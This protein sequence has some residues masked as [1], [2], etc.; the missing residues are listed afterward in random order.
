MSE[1]RTTT[2]VVE[3]A[4]LQSFDDFEQIDL[5]LRATSGRTT[6][7]PASLMPK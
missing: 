2:G 5:A 7:W 1:K 6:T 4:R 3:V